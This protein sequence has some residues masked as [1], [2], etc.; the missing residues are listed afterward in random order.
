MS[1]YWFIV[2]SEAPFLLE[3]IH[4][5][6]LKQTFRCDEKSVA[7]RWSR[8]GYFVS[9][10]LVLRQDRLEELG[11]N[12]TFAG[13]QHGIMKWQ[14]K[15]LFVNHKGKEDDERFVYTVFLRHCSQ[16]AINPRSLH[17]AHSIACTCCLCAFTVFCVH[18]CALFT[19]ALGSVSGF[20]L[21]W[22]NMLKTVDDISFY[23]A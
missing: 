12:S 13:V 20:V 15:S 14:R 17:E 21:L 5:I 8:C 16:T 18:L 9:A 19:T 10:T 2:L 6:Y 3:A 1:L 7:G 23:F 22:R 4:E 11:V